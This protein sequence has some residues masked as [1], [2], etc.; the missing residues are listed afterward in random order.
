MKLTK[1]GLGSPSE[2]REFR[3]ILSWGLLLFSMVCLPF[4]SQAQV[5]EI[6]GVVTDSTGKPLPDISFQVRG[7]KPLG[8]TDASG[9]F[10]ASVDKGTTLLFTSVSYNDLSLAID[11]RS[12]YAVVLSSKPSEL[13][14]VVVVGYGT[15]KKI[16]MTGSVATVSSRDL[17]NRPVTNVSSAL[18]GLAAGVNVRQSS[19][20]PRSDGA[21]ITIR[22]VATLSTTSALV[23]VDGIISSMD[24]V[25]PSDVESISVL[26]DA[27]STAI[28]GAMASNGVILVTT[29]KGANRKPRV[30]YSGVFSSTTPSGLPK[31]VSN[32]V[33]YMNLINEAYTNV[34]GTAQFTD[35]TIALW[36]S[37]QKIPNEL[38]P[39]GIP[40]YVAFPNTDWAK[41]LIQT[42]FL[43]N[44]NIQVSGGNE[45]TTY[46]LSLGY[47]K[48]P[49]MIE[50]SGIEKYRFRVNVESK[51]NSFITVG[52]Q[53]Y[54]YYQRNGL[55]N[56]TNL[57]NY[58]PQV[59]PMAYPEYKG[60]YATSSALGDAVQSSQ[61]LKGYLNS[62]LGSDVYTDVSTTWYGKVNIIKGLTFE[63]RFN[64]HANIE[65]LNQ[66]DNPYAAVRWN[67]AGT[68]STGYTPFTTYS[69]TA[70]SS[71]TTISAWYKTY[72]YT[73]ESLLRYNTSIGGVH[74]I[75]ALAGFNQ[76]YYKYYYTYASGVGLLDPSVSSIGSA[77][78]SN[79][80][81]GSATDYA[82]RSVF[83]RVTYNYK[84][85]YLFEANVRRDGS[86]KFGPAQRYGVFPSFSAG[87]NMT[88]EP[89]LQSLQD[90]N[91]QNV[92]LRASWG[93]V[94]NTASGNY[95]WQSTFSSV[96]YSFNGTV[97]AAIASGS[98]SNSSLRWETTNATNI[99]LDVLALRKLNVTLDW[100][101]RY[102]KGILF[103]PTMDITAGSASAP[104][105][106]LAQV[107]NNG[108]EL[109]AGWSGDIGKLKYSVSGNI[110]YN[111]YNTVKQYKGALV[112]G[113]TVTSGDSSYSSNIGAV[114]AG[115]TNRI[116]EG[117][118]INEFYMQTVYHGDGSFV[119]GGTATATNG[120]KSGMIRTED[121]MAWVVA[122]QAAGNTFSPVNTVAKGNLYY[123]DLI[124]ADNN[125]DKIYGNAN[126]AVFKK[127]STTPKYVFGL[128]LNA[129]YDNFTFNMIWAG[130]A[131]FKVYWNQ[132]YYNS[133]TMPLQ[134][135]VSEKIANDHYFYDPSNTSDSRTNLNATYPRL[136]SSDAIDNVVSDFWLYNASYLRLK[137][138]QIGYNIPSK[139]L[140]GGKYFQ[141]FNV[142]VSAE[143][144]LTITS[145]P[146]PDPE[147]GASA[148]GYPTMKQFAAGVNITF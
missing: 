90:H 46:N 72:D 74:N 41:A 130:A 89:F 100:Y 44:H 129:S 48:N 141:R 75:S 15:Q 103:T 58:M 19:G 148:T 91:I 125:G 120:P 134:G 52:T 101:S 32:S 124:Y 12:D 85:T 39:G 77:T 54:G 114:S 123:G 122:M 105:V 121:D 69:A 35:A 82:F 112:A 50:H 21:T 55:A 61:G 23:L 115:S 144:L 113:W 30:T 96:P 49:G 127:V 119:A 63:P 128:N 140:G 4:L 62:A 47:L 11:D 36:D 76:Y 10:S 93:Q 92:K 45:N 98:F 118:M 81:T 5:K 65:E 29:K 40:N 56:T 73:L 139:V 67:W 79:K 68:E 64:Y 37:V 18:G 116:L 16:N 59:S 132:G 102:T 7:G 51:I 9:R 111:Y 80:T 26:K 146:A 104:T 131:G 14:E 88:N 66:W 110:A 145:S 43:Q 71:L 8:V 109:T 137:N 133:I 126:D 135:N 60:Q 38:T 6:H 83:G 13:N 34:G 22:G 84:G 78:T 1:V 136:K 27:A 147:Q 87:W 17:E 117:H 99:G 108:L 94:G 86:S 97:V 20:D 95:S 106:N 24:A 3:K 57:F 53:T 143:N 142:F 33:K 42:K 107:L 28:Y 31:W 138:I 25:N 70:S 2:N